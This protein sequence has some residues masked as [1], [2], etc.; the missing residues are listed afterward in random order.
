MIRSFK[1]IVILAFMLLSSGMWPAQQCRAG[2]ARP[3]RQWKYIVI[4][5]SATICGN[6]NIF[7]RYH[8]GTCAE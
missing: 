7:D 5:Y 3:K 2:A 8:A 6:L 1:C 4:H